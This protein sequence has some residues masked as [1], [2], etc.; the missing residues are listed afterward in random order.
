MTLATGASAGSTAESL[1]GAEASV[2]RRLAANV[3]SLFFAWLLPRLSLAAAVIVAARVLGA[4][5]F[6]TYGTAAAYAVILSI[7]ATLGMQPL[8]VREIAR[9]PGRAAAFVRAADLIKALA[10]FVMLLAL[11]ALAR[12][13]AYDGEVLVAALLLGVG[14]AVGSFVENRSARVQAE[15]RMHV[16][17]EASALAGLIAGALGIALVVATRSVV[18]FCAAAVAGQLAALGWLGVRA[19]G[20]DSPRW[21]AAEMRV[22]ARTFLPYA[23]AFI[24]LTLHAK[25]AVL[26]LA[27]WRSAAEVGVFVAGYKFIDLA[28]AMVIVLVAAAYPRLSRSFGKAAGQWR[29][30]ARLSELLL[31]IIAPA[32]AAL[33]LARGPAVSLLFGSQ[34]VAAVPVV[35]LLAAALPALAINLAGTWVLGA[36]GRMATVAPLYALAVVV[37]VGLCALWVPAHGATGAATALLTAEWALAIAM[38]ATL[39][40]TAHVRPRPIVLLASAGVAALT[41][42]VLLAPDPTGGI[43]RAFGLVVLTLALYAASGALAPDD[44]RVLRELLRVRSTGR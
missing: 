5:R 43:L 6:G 32:A 34:Y 18:W 33:W 4:E 25:V 7:L 36:A 38:F 44:R 12:P 31:L 42:L 1:S 39:H 2:A 37:D 23:A 35:A 29:A 13:L 20:R 30:G 14:Y 26:L 28:Q 27:R 17:T 21:P 41:W 40:M 3:A 8:L 16:W 9:A 11:L 19:P 22:L 15:E 10:G 24:A